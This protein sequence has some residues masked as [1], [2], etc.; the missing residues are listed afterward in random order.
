MTAEAL[1]DAGLGKKLIRLGL[2]DTYAHG[3]SRPYLM[4]YYGLDAIALVRGIE[5][6]MGIETGIDESALEAVRVEAV[7]SSV[8]A[9]A[10]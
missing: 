5:R 3:G 9:E 2:Q 10:L 8:K 4:N 6:L 1:A 7:H